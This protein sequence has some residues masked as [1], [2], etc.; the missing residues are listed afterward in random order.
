[1]LLLIVKQLS[2]FQFGSDAAV[3]VGLVRKPGRE[4]F[5]LQSWEFVQPHSH[6]ILPCA[7]LTAH[8]WQQF[9]G[10]GGGE[11]QHLKVPYSRPSLGLRALRVTATIFEEF[12]FWPSL[13]HHDFTCCA[14]Q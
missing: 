13:P 4:D 1:M 8:S 11:G 9:G 2:Y 3:H 14:L 6:L 10:E 5:F 12:D 7:L